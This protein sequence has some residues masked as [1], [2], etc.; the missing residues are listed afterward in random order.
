MARRREPGDPLRERRDEIA[1]QDSRRVRVGGD[2]VRFDEA[3]GFRVLDGLRTV[4]PASSSALASCSSS[5]T[6]SSRALSR[7]PSSASIASYVS[8]Q[9]GID[10]P[11][12]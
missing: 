3:N 12:D 8:P 11:L 1:D 10:C 2:F 4:A 7:S 5:R 9:T 6:T